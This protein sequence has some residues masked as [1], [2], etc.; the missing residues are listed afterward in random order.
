MFSKV[1]PVST[2]M[3]LVLF[4]F[5]NCASQKTD[6]SHGGTDGEVRIVDRWD[7]QKLELIAI[8]N[9]V[10]SSHTEVE[11]HGVCGDQSQGDVIEWQ[12]IVVGDIPEVVSS[13]EV[14]CDQ[15][16]FQ[17]PAETLALYE[18]CDTQIQVRAV[19]TGVDYDY[20]EAMLSTECQ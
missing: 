16:G 13:G 2:L 7:Q 4:Q 6:A 10:G 18:N 1:I 19:R 8:Q 15:G 9:S 3:L 14:L 17:L 12:A 20:A 11:V 5:Q